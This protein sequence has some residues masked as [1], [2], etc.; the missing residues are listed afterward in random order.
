MNVIRKAD[1]SDLFAI[2][3]MQ[4]TPFRDRVFIDPL[5]PRKEFVERAESRIQ[6]G[7]EHY[8]VQ[9]SQG[10]IVGFI[11]FVMKS[12]WHAFTWGKWL[13]TLV[14]ASNVVAFNRL[15]LPR[16]IF[17]VREDN[18]RLIH[19]YEKFEFRKVWQEFIFYRQTLLAPL[20]TT[21]VTY[22]DITHEE[23]AVRADEMLKHSLPLTFE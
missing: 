2:H 10:T 21:N 20:R 15:E 11:R 13:N 7:L 18:K 23:F 14:Y 16:L 1:R 5:L 12:N 6:K 9:D 22:Y 4:D 17:P 3:R 8:F 19:L